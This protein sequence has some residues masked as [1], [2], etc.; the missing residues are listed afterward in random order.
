M[1]DPVPVDNPVGFRNTGRVREPAPLPRRGLLGNVPYAR[2]S[3][4]N[5]LAAPSSS[6]PAL[7]RNN[8]TPRSRQYR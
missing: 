8:W 5:L 4:R 3:S 7:F 6:A 1:T 2:D